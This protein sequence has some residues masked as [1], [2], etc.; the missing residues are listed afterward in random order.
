MVKIKDKNLKRDRGKGKAVES[1]GL[2]ER[3]MGLALNRRKKSLVPGMSGNYQE[4]ELAMRI[5]PFEYT[6]AS[7]SESR[8]H[9]RD[10]H[11]HEPGSPH[12]QEARFGGHEQQLHPE[13]EQEKSKNE[14]IPRTRY[15][16]KV[17]SYPLDPYDST[18]LE[19]CVSLHLLASSCFALYWIRPVTDRLRIY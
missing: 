19:R 10:E 3:F 18:L 9:E 4:Q 13:R 17:G 11:E 1:D 12:R 16:N 14:E 2:G 7:R 8:K 5:S 15:A 6:V